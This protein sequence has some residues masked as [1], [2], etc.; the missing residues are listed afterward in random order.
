MATVSG[1]L[2]GVVINV[3][4]MTNSFQAAM[5]VNTNAVTTPG[6]G[7]CWNLI[8]FESSFDHL[9]WRVEGAAK[10]YTAQSLGDF[11]YVHVLP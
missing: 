9:G 11:W 3:S 7:F 10:V 1:C 5:K 8:T 4:A 2:L 6:A